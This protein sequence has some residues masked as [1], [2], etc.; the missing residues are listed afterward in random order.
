MRWFEISGM[1]TSDLEKGPGIDFL[2][3]QTNPDDISHRQ[4]GTIAPD[5]A[6]LLDEYSR[7]VVS[8]ADRVS[9]AVVNIEIKQRRDSRHSS[10]EIGGS[11]SGFIVAPDG[12]ILTNSHVVHDA[13]EITEI[14]RASCRERGEVSV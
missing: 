9:P 12:F 11:G 14:G 1:P 13:I 6:A 4:P 7:T 2:L 8:A 5:D 3:G 10:R